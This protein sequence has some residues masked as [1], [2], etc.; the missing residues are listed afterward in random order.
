MID[1]E[2]LIGLAVI[3]GLGVALVALL[4]RN[5]EPKAAPLAAVPPPPPEPPPPPPPAPQI[6]VDVDVTVTTK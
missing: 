6:D 4:P 5:D 2:I 1:I 3:A